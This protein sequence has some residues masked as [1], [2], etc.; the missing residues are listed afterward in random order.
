MLPEYCDKPASANLYFNMEVNKFREEIN[1][2]SQD[3]R[4]SWPY[5]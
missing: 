1:N 2:S 4:S 5:N 3:S